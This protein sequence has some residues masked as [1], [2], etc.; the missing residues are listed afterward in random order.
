MLEALVRASQPLDGTMCPANAS[1]PL[2]GCLPGF[3]CPTAAVMK[4][5]PVG[6]YC[7]GHNSA[8]WPCPVLA[9]CLSPSMEHPDWS[10]MGVVFMLLLLLVMMT[11]LEYVHMRGRCCRQAVT[12]EDE[13]MQLM[14][15]VG[16]KVR[17][18]PARGWLLLV[19]C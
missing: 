9:S 7:P 12:Q 13:V 6:F 17:R 5:C 19:A 11:V 15:A 10:W 1:D 14:E 18:R 8:P 16:F 2:A 4:P 3:F